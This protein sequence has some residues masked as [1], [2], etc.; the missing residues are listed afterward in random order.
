[1]LITREKAPDN[2]PNEQPQEKI[3]TPSSPPPSCYLGSNPIKPGP[4]LARW[5]IRALALG[6]AAILSSVLSRGYGLLSASSVSV[7]GLGI[8]G[9]VK[10][11]PG[12]EAEVADL[13]VLA[14]QCDPATS[15]F[16]GWWC[17]CPQFSSSLSELHGCLCM[18]GLLCTKCSKHP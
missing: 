16:P 5:V 17:L 13:P 14:L 10:G 15:E 6:I 2:K 12:E 11:Q 9:L 8:T 18:P 7:C 3:T 4:V 1:M